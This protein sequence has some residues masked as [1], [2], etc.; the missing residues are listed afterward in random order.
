MQTR[1]PRIFV[2]TL[3]C[4]E[5]D[6]SFCTNSLLKQK[7]VEVTHHII[8]NL[9]EKDAH[10]ALWAAW[11]NAKDVGE[12]DFFVKLDADT[13]LAHENVLIDIAKVFMSNDSIT[14]LQAP[15]HDFYTDT[16]IAGLNC[17]TPVVVFNDTKDDL[18]CDRNID[19]NHNVVVGMNNVPA[20]LRPAGLHCHYASEIQAFRYGYHRALK[21]QTQLL[22]TVQVAYENH[23]DNLRRY[24]IEGWKLASRQRISCDYKSKE[25]LECF[26]AIDTVIK[27]EK[28][29][30]NR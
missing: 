7:S 16:N 20:S 17:F 29:T 28:S 25:F 6:F 14:G 23:K 19:V 5:N 24:V 21:K 4:D 30:T 9:S 1:H 15:L 12:Y 27:N 8:S 3:H 22:N 10:N 18:F 2:G 26:N 13:V 11:R